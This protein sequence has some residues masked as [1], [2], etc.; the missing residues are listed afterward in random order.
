MTKVAIYIFK[1]K[2]HPLPLHR[3]TSQSDLPWF[4]VRVIGDSLTRYLPQNLYS[5]WF[6]PQIVTKPECRVHHNQRIKKCGAWWRCFNPHVI[7]LHVG[8]NDL[9]CSVLHRDIKNYEQMIR[10][11]HDRFPKATILLNSILPRFDDEVLSHKG[12]IVR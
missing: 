8:T 1:K 10:L 9:D 11:P 6:C 2:N 5:D 3:P 4:R 12:H 7:D